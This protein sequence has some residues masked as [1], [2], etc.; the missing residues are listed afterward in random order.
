MSDPTHFL[1]L[2]PVPAAASLLLLACLAAPGVQAETRYIKPTLDVALRK[3]QANNARLVAT[4]P[5]GEQVDL[6]QAGAEWSQVRRKDGTEGWVRSRANSRM[7][8]A[9]SDSSTISRPMISSSTSSMLITP[10]TLPYS[11]TTTNRCW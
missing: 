3:A 5:L 9:L 8:R 11:S 10:V 1:R 6:L 4:V 2:R 7:L